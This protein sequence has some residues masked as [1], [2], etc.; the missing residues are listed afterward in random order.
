VVVYPASQ[1]TCQVLARAPLA[2]DA[3]LTSEPSLNP[4]FV[5]MLAKE[6]IDHLN[7]HPYHRMADFANTALVLTACER[8]LAETKDLVCMGDECMDML[9]EKIKAREA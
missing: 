1:G 7:H 5:A 9:Q 4:E 3:H 6:L 8:R 2:D